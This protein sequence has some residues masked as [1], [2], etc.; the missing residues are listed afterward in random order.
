MSVRIVPF[1]DSGLKNFELI[2]VRSV[3]TSRMEGRRTETASS[4][5]GY[6]RATI[7]TPPLTPEL[8][9]ELEAFALDANAPDAVFE[10]FDQE[11][12]RPRA[13]SAALADASGGK[14]SV[15]AIT[16]PTSLRV[17]SLPAG[18]VL[19]R[20]DRVEVRMSETLRSLHMVMENVAAS[21]SGSATFRVEPPIDKDNFNTTAEAIFEKP[22]CLMKLDALVPV[23]KGWGN[24]QANITANEVFINGA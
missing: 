24:R 9:A 4:G 1:P 17:G 18:F 11:R 10:V 14:G 5:Q 2:F 23:D 8:L 22:S 6:S 20:G 7:T 21:G 3:G 13:Y 12:P 19:Q 15:T 16:E